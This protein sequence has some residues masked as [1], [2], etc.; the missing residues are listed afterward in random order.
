LRRF[1]HS[2]LPVIAFLASAGLLVWHYSH[3]TANSGLI[4]EAFGRR[5]D[6]YPEIAGRL[7]P[8]P[9]RVMNEYMKVEKG[10][11]VAMLDPGPSN[12]RIAALEGEME[13]VA[14]E[15]KSTAAEAAF[16][17]ARVIG[18]FAGDLAQLYEHKSRLIVERATTEALLATATVKTLTETAR[19]DLLEKAFQK[20]AVPEHEVLEAAT[21][22][23]EASENAKGYE[24]TIAT[25]DEQLDD[26]NKR[27]ADLPSTPA[28]DPKVM[29]EPV[30]K[31]IEMNRRLVEEQKVLA[32]MLV[33]KAPF[34]GMITQVHLQP[35]QAVQT[36]LPIMTIATTDVPY[37]VTYI[38]PD[39]WMRPQ[40]GMEADVLFR[41]SNQS[42]PGTVIQ[43]GAQV[44]M[45]SIKQQ[46]DPRIQE[47]GLP[48]AI[49]LDWSDDLL[50]KLEPRPGE[51]VTVR[52]HP[53]RIRPVTTATVSNVLE[54]HK[55]SRV[56]SSARK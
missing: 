53:D 7:V 42:V 27:I 28:L 34:S 24:K 48:V 22:M 36:G 45:V 12:A 44:E 38:R 56:A 1:C 41:S 35:G 39:Q 10:Q 31:E 51:L 5:A 40:L 25:I 37:I 14:A 52:M 9:G 16:E 55:E 32:E 2:A 3:N 11:V 20:K 54:R 8:L 15:L 13:R 29:L 6:I 23:K 18:G 43:I 19:H 50:A 46:F 47:W 49:A 4:G 21:S 17:N 26:V 30:Y 33:I